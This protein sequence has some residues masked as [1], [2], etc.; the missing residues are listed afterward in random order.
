MSRTMPGSGRQGPA[1]PGDG[2]HRALRPSSRRLRGA[3][4]LV[5]LLTALGLGAAFTLG[6]ADATTTATTGSGLPA[7]SQSAQVSRI[8]GTLPSGAVAPALVVY[9]NAD[10]TPLT[11]PQR[12]QIEQ[13]AVPLGRLG[14]GGAPARAAYAKDRVATV[15]VPLR[16][17][18]GDDENA[19]RI[20]TIRRTASQGLQAPLRAQVTG[21]PAFS[22]D[23]GKVFDGADTTL[24]L[25]TASVVAL[26]L[27]V[28]YR[29]PLLWVVPLLVVGAGDR[30][31][32]VLVGVLAPIAGVDVDAASAGILSV[33]VFGAG[34]DY[35]LLL[36]SRYRDELH[37]EGDR[38]R[39]M[40]RAWRGTAPAVLAS[41][42]TV[43]LSL[44]T[45]LA[46][47]LTGNRGLGFA[48]AVGILTAMLCG[49]V[50][51]PAALVLPG[52][53]IFW[54]FVPR[55]G[56]PVT[57]DRRGGWAR[58]G[59]AVARRPAAVTA[60][61]T[62]VLVLL[63]SGALGL[64]TGLSQNDS[65]RSRPEAVLG[66]ETL[67]SVLPAGA[68]DPL[69]VVSAS[70]AAD[71]VVR[72]ARGVPGVA[73]VT[74]GERTAR[75]A[76]AE[77]VLEDAAGTRASDAAIARLR[78]RLAEVPRADALVGGT[79]AETYDVARATARDT[80]VVVPLVLAIVLV[81]LVVLLRALVAPL[82][83]VLTVIASYFAALG[84]S[85]TLF[86]TV[87]DFP[88]LDAGVPLLSFLFLV[89]LGVDYNIFLIARTREDTLA[90]HGT[91]AAVLRALASTGG[92]ITSAGI[93]LA[94]VFAVLGVL[95]LI[96]LTQIG[97]IVGVG[98]LLDTLLVRTVLVPALV[99]LT[100]RRF[101]WP[102]RPE[103]AARRPSDGP[104]AP[105]RHGATAVSGPR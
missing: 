101:W 103:E 19:A 55:V 35:A 79:T 81:V 33:L 93:L 20:D 36:V 61:G 46:A 97:V 92:V 54:P 24:L 23:L 58:L 80:R 2:P 22:A 15:A 18:V 87:Y 67:Q 49:L 37:L 77:V 48:G 59:R 1:A 40:A 75:H 26:L 99:L 60:A 6:P 74:P 52:R 62:A 98:V 10:G 47:E 95:P 39:A 53:G 5:L 90:G 3:A 32:S 71:E 51:L 44:L 29:S 13:R 25:V 12:A 21:G 43:V 42:T 7:S 30:L 78:G 100:G 83:L 4:W 27:L 64:H 70:A 89:A 17:G 73:Q 91:R 76:A 105:D 66:Q 50:V 104:A 84:A 86:R 16:S 85:W 8:V 96:T 28:T 14:L 57:A 11:A 94:A 69:T 68:G 88:A 72:A 56:D 45:L 82:L 102:G 34:T 65:F 41:G 63:A 31:A 38:F 9:S